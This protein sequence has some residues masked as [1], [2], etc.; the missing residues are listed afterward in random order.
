MSTS[1]SENIIA[2]QWYSLICHLPASS[3]ESEQIAFLEDL[4]I[5]KPAER[6]IKSDSMW[7]SLVA[8]Y[9]AQV[10]Q[11]KL[12]AI[13]GQQLEELSLFDV[14]FYKSTESAENVA[15]QLAYRVDYDLFLDAE[16]VNEDM[17]L[18]LILWRKCSDKSKEED[19]ERM[20]LTGWILQH[21]RI[22][23]RLESLA[24]DVYAMLARYVF[25]DPIFSRQL[26]N[27]KSCSSDSKY[28]GG[29]PPIFFL[30][31]FPHAILYLHHTEASL[32]TAVFRERVAKMIWKLMEMKFPPLI[33]CDEINGVLNPLITQF[34][35]YWDKQS[36][37]IQKSFRNKTYDIQKYY[38]FDEIKEDTLSIP[39]SSFDQIIAFHRLFSIIG[40][41]CYV[42]KDG[43]FKT[44]FDFEH[45]TFVDAFVVV[46]KH[47]VTSSSS[48]EDSGGVNQRSGL[49]IVTADIKP[50][51]YNPCFVQ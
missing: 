50:Q 37:D 16:D 3:T 20:I 36:D 34:K 48:S 17:L 15:K 31:L 38:T 43:K 35:V 11:E 19:Q 47:P 4:G 8:I 7:N 39:R 45:P 10:H 13:E 26:A 30:N 23:L 33:E 5:S 21:R 32:N 46:R 28:F 44:I 18:Q 25:T 29:T 42:G 2:I 51:N 27:N 6:K 22:Q 49:I 41:Q 12:K 24:A 40:S 14:L 9:R 1:S